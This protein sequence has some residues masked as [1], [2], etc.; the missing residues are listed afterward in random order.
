MFLFISS[1]VIKKHR[2]YLIKY[3]KMLFLLANRLINNIL[4]V[5]FT[6]FDFRSCI[7]SYIRRDNNFII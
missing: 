5:A 7:D 2:L 4:Y 3:G 6:R 1:K